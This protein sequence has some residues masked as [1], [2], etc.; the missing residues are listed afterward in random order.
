MAVLNL[1]AGPGAGKSTIA[2]ALFAEMKWQKYDV[3]L[4]TEYAKKLVWQKS[5][6]LLVDQFKVTAEQNHRMYILNDQL[7][8][9]VTDS[10]LPIALYYAPDYYKNTFPQFVM[11]VFN[12]YDNINFFIK[13]E[14]D[15]VPKG[16][17]Q[18]YEEALAA[19]EGIM[20]IMRKYQVPFTLI[21]GRRYEAVNIIMESVRCREQS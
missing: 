21:P 20:E 13:R 6:N 18:T 3:E 10:P 9:I 16:R 4:V 11:D 15:Y 12:S 1:F 2:A 19:D 8:W 14:K 17:N 7:K 5:H